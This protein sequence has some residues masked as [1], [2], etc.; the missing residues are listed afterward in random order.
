MGF[1]VLE[2]SLGVR[3]LN[4]DYGRAL[5]AWRR[6]GVKAVFKERLW[7]ELEAPQV[8]KI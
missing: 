2:T 1:P 6:E 7:R 5:G 8:W 4:P 3:P